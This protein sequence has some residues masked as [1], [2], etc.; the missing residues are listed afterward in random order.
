MKTAKTNKK[1]IS[2]LCA[3]CS[4]VFAFIIGTT[5][6]STSFTFNYGTDNKSTTAYMANNQHTLINDTTLYPVSFGKGSHNFE[7][8]LKY[9]ID[10]EFDFR[11]DY[12]LQWKNSA[13][14]NVD[15]ST[16]NVILNFANR[17]NLIVDENHI[18]YVAFNNEN[19]AD[20]IPSGVQAGDGKITVISG[21]SYV[22]PEDINYYGLYLTINASVTITPKTGTYTIEH[23]LVK[24]IS[25]S[26]SAK[27]WLQYKN[28]KESSVWQ[29]TENGETVTKDAYIMLYNYRHD[30]DHGVPFPGGRTAYN[31]TYDGQKVTTAK[32]LGGNRAYAG[33]G[34]YIITG[35]YSVKLKVK[36]QGIWRKNGNSPGMYENSILFNYTNKWHSLGVDDT[37][38]IHNTCAY[39]YEIPAYSTCYV[40]I[41]DSV[42]VISA[43]ADP[44]N[45]YDSHRAVIHQIIINDSIITSNS[46]YIQ[47]FMVNKLDE[48]NG[49]LNYL[50]KSG[51]YSPIRAEDYVKEEITIVNE[52]K[53][54]NNL[55][56]VSSSGGTSQLSYYTNVTLINNTSDEK[57]V[58]ISYKLTYRVSNGDTG[59][60]NIDDNKTF[61]G[62]KYYTLTETI[63][64]NFT[65]NSAKTSVI[66]APYSSVSVCD[67]FDVTSGFNSVVISKCGGVYD[68]WVQLTPT[69][70]SD[71]STTNGLEL[72]STYEGSKLTVRVKNNSNSVLSGI[73]VANLKVQQFDISTLKTANNGTSITNA[74]TQVVS[75]P[76]DWKSSFWK[77]YKQESG[78][79]VPVTEYTEFSN[80]TYYSIKDT[81]DYNSATVAPNSLSGV[82]LNPGDSYVILTY[83]NTTYTQFIVTGNVTATTQE[84]P[85]EPILV[86]NGTSQAYIENT[87][88]D[89]S[90]FV[91]IQGSITATDF[92][93][94]F[95][96]EYSYYIGVLRPK[97][98]INVPLAS[99]VEF[100]PTNETFSGITGWND[101]AVKEI[102]KLFTVKEI[103]K[104]FT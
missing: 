15:V 99:I 82:K 16:E 17:D 80:G 72:E 9:A 94:S 6:A 27:A 104:L 81:V 3:I 25:N 23:T 2:I 76:L 60:Y 83:S 61:G 11:I 5:F 50:N 21:V 10:Y 92:N 20:P 100:V 26:E 79:M 36:V 47:S 69:V 48:E 31:K 39:I 29:T 70:T 91:R 59:I 52:S 93:S 84:Q 68:A 66:I 34:M 65:I 89:T 51:S 30:E 22:D 57:Q 63:N 75:E 90:Y 56:E 71:T 101:D 53:Y 95:G 62:G 4:V 12:S 45:V 49:D 55:Y 14:V 64:N 97:Q 7:I 13:G 35:E 78:K 28:C 38:Y 1:L 54:L 24:N 19:P 87:S 102:E 73:N 8:A 32:W 96:D 40:D 103:Q 43:G 98:I 46:N 18:Y 58:S 85:T 42:E 33:T 86:N 77:Y 67:L 88:E 44:S 41:L 74:Y 37:N